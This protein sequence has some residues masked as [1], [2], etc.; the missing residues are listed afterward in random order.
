MELTEKRFRELAVKSYQN[1]IYLFT[2]FLNMAEIDLLYQ[3]QRELSYIPFEVFG[4]TE[5]CERVMVRFGSPELF[6]YEEPFP[7][8]CI[9]AEPLIE[10]FADTFSHR[11]FLGALMNLG[12]EREVVGDIAIKGK[13]AYI[14]CTEKMAQYIAENLTQVKHTRVSCSILS[15]APDI[16]KPVLEQ[17]EVTAASER[18]DA[19]LGKLCSLSRSQSI[20]AFREKKVFV[21]GRQCENNSYQLKP[22]DVVTCRGFGKFIYKGVKYETK[23]GKVCAEVTVY[24]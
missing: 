7:I 20:L 3:M 10:K 19:V 24:V 12:I 18:I 15:E 11:D 22:G 13:T 14:F 2:N 21:N 6:G 23:K 9:K 8:C 5:N 1:N 16:L 17:R 4:G